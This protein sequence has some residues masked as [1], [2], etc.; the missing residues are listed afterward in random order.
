MRNSWAALVVFAACQPN[1]PP[2]HLASSTASHLAT[3][4]APPPSPSVT[5]AAADSRAGAF[6]P[7]APAV[8]KAKVV[9]AIQ[10]R[11]QKMKVFAVKDDPKAQSLEYDVIPPAA[12]AALRE[13]KDAIL[14][15]AEAEIP[16]AVTRRGASQALGATFE[17]G[18]A[19]LSKS[20]A[21]SVNGAISLEL[22][23]VPDQEDRWVLSACVEEEPGSDCMV[24]L[25]ERRDGVLRL[26]LVSRSDD[27]ESISSARQG[28]EWAVSPPLDD[29]LYLLHAYTYPWSSQTRDFE[30]VALAPGPDSRRPKVVAKGKSDDSAFWQEGFSLRAEPDAFTVLFSVR[31]ADGLSRVSRVHEWKRQGSAF[32]YLRA[33]QFPTDLRDKFPSSE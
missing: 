22:A 26:L 8:E 10:T 17:A 2:D 14:A 18:G 33:V 27:Y 16:Q 29:K 21:A 31:S 4:S 15:V 32:R 7:S 11:L 1:Q 30:Y 24:A 13:L 19:L 20:G 12:R 5:A 9:A 3:A 25:Y 28:T 23:A 6:L